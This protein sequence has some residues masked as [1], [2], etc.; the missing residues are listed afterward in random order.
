MPARTPLFAK[1]TKVTHRG[2]SPSY[3][4]I[5]KWRGRTLFERSK[6]ILM[7]R[8]SR[9][10]WPPKSA[11]RFA[12]CTACDRPKSQTSSRG[13]R[14]SGLLCPRPCAPQAPAARAALL[15]MDTPRS[16]TAGFA[17]PRTSSLMRCAPAI[18]YSG[19]D[20]TYPPH[21]TPMIEIF[22]SSTRFNAIDGMRPAANPIIKIPPLRSHAL[23]R[24][25]E[26][27]A[28]H[29]IVNRIGA[30]A[31][32]DLLHAIHPAGTRII[33]RVIRALLP[34]KRELRFASGRRDHLRAQR[35]A[36]LNRRPSRRRSHP[37]GPA[38]TRLRGSGSDASWRNMT[39]DKRSA[40]PRRSKPIAS[41]IANMLDSGASEYS[42]NAPPRGIA[43]TRSPSFTFVTPHPTAS[44]TPATSA[45]GVNGNGGFTWY[46]PCTCKMSKKF[47]AAA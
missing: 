5:G 27:V 20:N 36:D 8:S 11:A 42:A 31:L 44:T 43:I 35:L 32:R 7:T 21:S 14:I 37:R 6:S 39:S 38:A 19:C 46:F 33:D 4:M 1:L 15:R 29:W 10:G 25:I 23:C 9:S 12:K 18:S 16:P 34:R 45:P 24:Q 40:S 13:T 26:N 22:F 17:P 3:R 47:S 41:G 2:T 30:A 28:A